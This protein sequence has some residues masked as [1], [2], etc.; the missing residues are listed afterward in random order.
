MI[1][2]TDFLERSLSALEML[3]RRPQIPRSESP[4]QYLDSGQWLCSR[5]WPKASTEHCLLGWL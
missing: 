3:D 4:T 5:N 1:H 2:S